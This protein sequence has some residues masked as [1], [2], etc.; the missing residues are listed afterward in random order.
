MGALND[1]I[2]FVCDKIILG[3]SYYKLKGK[4]PYLSILGN[5]DLLLY[6]NQ[7][8][9]SFIYGNLWVLSLGMSILV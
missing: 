1:Q 9:L 8:K 4:Y 5:I 2:L 7:A 6:W 3:S